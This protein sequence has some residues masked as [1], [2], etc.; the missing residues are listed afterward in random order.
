MT[1]IHHTYDVD[2]MLREC[3]DD[4]LRTWHPCY[5]ELDWL[6][7]ISQPG[8]HL[9]T[10]GQSSYCLIEPLWSEHLAHLIVAPDKRGKT[11]WQIARAMLEWIEAQGIT[12]LIATVEER[13]TR[14]FL[15]RLGFDQVEGQPAI[16]KWTAARPL[17]SSS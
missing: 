1:M 3:A 13:K 11:G 14:L 9:I 16:L 8:W 6:A 12:S 4:D 10:D 15:R 2:R 17:P 5:D 7:M